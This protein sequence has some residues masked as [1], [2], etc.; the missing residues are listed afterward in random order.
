MEEFWLTPL[1]SIAL[2]SLCVYLCTALLRTWFAAGSLSS[3]FSSSLAIKTKGLTF[4]FRILWY[5]EEFIVCSMTARCTVCKT[6]RDHHPS[7]TV[8]DSWFTVFALIYCL[9]V[10]TKC[11]VSK[12]L[13]FGPVCLNNIVSEI[14]WFVHM[15]HSYLKNHTHLVFFCFFL[16]LRYVKTLWDL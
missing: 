8:H 9:L 1:C 10:F 16:I 11:I 5:S 2:F 7:T 3:S 12:H 14:L 6:S 15:Q 13:H 4:E